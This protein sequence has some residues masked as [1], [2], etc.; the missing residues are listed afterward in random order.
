MKRHVCYF[1]VFKFAQEKRRE[2][3]GAGRVEMIYDRRKVKV[4]KEAY[5]IEVHI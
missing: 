4:K 3:E 1:E 2:E 5:K